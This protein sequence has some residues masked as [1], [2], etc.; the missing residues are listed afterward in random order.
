MSR[1]AILRLR[2]L[3][4][5][6]IALSAV[7]VAA[8]QSSATTYRISGK[9]VDA[10]TGAALARCSVQIADIKQRSAG[11]TVTS[12]EDGSFFFGSV[13]RGKYSLT[14]SRRGYLT[15]SYEEHDQYSTAIAVGPRLVSEGLTFRLMPEAVLSG[16]ITDEAG[17]PIRGA[18]VRLYIDDDT[19]GTHSTQQR[20]SAM[21]DDRGFYEI[22]SLRPGAYFLL[23]TARP[24]YAQYSFNESSGES[25]QNA[26]DVGYPPT[27]YPGVTDEDAA[28]PIPVRGGEHLEASVMLSAQPSVHVRIALPPGDAQGGVGA[29]ISRTIL[30]QT[31][32]LPAQF[33]IVN[34]NFV[35][36]QGILPGHYQIAISKSSNTNPQESETRHFDADVLAG[37]EELN[38]NT[39]AADVTIAAR[40]VSQ[41]KLPAGSGISLHVPHSRAQQHYGTLDENGTVSIDVPPGTYEVGGHI[42]QMYLEKITAQDAVLNG[43]MLQVKAGSSP[44]LEIT[45]GSGYGTIDGTAMRGGQPASGVMVLLAPEDPK[46]N[47][48]LFRRDQSDSDG[49]FTLAQIIPGRYH[50]LAID[51]G[52]ELEWANPKVLESFLPKSAAIEIHPNDQ[53]KDSVQVQSR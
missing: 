48:L 7:A 23:I 17:E 27:F 37:T 15:Q 11:N 47:Q 12:G 2:S 8:Q 10:H 49:T 5:V 50:L 6:L 26:L 30:G 28:T 35:E 25:G 13:P 43:R 34:G 31:E 21:T 18:Q 32:V 40:V 20:Q 4:V 46:N 14:A 53:V 22:A 41:G 24:W 45:A 3:A 36:L 29:Q 16:T 51:R 39:A 33:G 38:E 1:P 19:D 9:M 44:K 42:P 52:W